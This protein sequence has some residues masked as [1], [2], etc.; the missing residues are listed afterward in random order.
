MSSS[1]LPPEGPQSSASP[2]SGP[3]RFFAWIRGTGLQ[4]DTSDRWVAGVCSGV[5]HRLGVDPLVVRAAL[6][7]LLLFG[8]LGI[9]LYALAWAFLPTQ[10]GTI[11]AEEALRG[12][13]SSIALLVIV[14][15]VVVGAMSDRSAPWVLIPLGVVVW[16]L[17]RHRRGGFGRPAA[18]PP[19]EGERAA[20]TT[21]PSPGGLAVPGAAA[22]A[23][24]SAPTVPP[25]SAG[26]AS[27]STH[28]LGPGRTW[29]PSTPSAPV[30]PRQ[31]RPGIGVLGV[32]AV[33]GLAVL[34][35]GVAEASGATPRPVALGLVCAVATLGLALVVIGLLGRR[36]SGLAALGVT[37][38]V[39]A[40]FAVLLPASV[41]WSNI[42][43]GVGQATW[44]PSAA[45]AN[46][47][48][49]WGTGEATLDLGAFPAPP[50]GSE[51][52]SAS[53]GLGQLVVVV[54]AGRSIE[55]DA[56]VGAGE[57]V[58]RTGS[59][60]GATTFRRDGTD[61]HERVLVGSGPPDT[62]VTANVG[63]GSLTVVSP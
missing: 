32:I 49:R 45:E 44:R 57:I 42:G 43:D 20:S 63:L 19:P 31:R 16:L 5:A 53:V 8:G 39:V 24:A 18:A 40:A 28:G 41:S 9:T 58:R 6:L 23:G 52:V 25:T 7:V 62:R 26:T 27:G 30:P 14:G 10:D 34:A 17:V 35:K 36:A 11:R 48:L 29:A 47:S 22:Q 3:E 60:E 13:A 1:A 2:P 51:P 61:L 15:I 4:R 12:D 46:T 33:V 37:A 21:S 54:P 55:V 59:Q 50:P 56:T 38:A